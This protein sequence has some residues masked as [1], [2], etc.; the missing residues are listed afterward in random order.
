MVAGAAKESAC[1]PILWT[2]GL[3]GY[4]EVGSDELDEEENEQ[5]S[6]G[7]FFVAEAENRDGFSIE[8]LEVE[9]LSDEPEPSSS[10]RTSLGW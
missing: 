8:E 5:W 1:R 9:G 6:P 4:G 7:Y 3:S 2:R 10:T